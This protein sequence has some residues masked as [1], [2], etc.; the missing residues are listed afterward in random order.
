[1]VHWQAAD[2]DVGARGSVVL[3]KLHV[4]HAVTAQ[5][6]WWG[7]SLKQDQVPALLYNPPDEGASPA[8]LVGCAAGARTELEC[9][10]RRLTACMRKWTEQHCEEAG[11]LQSLG[12]CPR[13][14][15]C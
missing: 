8:L 15:T 2:G 12:A 10:G 1:M 11:V 7:S 4:V 5:Q 9:M 13:G 6:G 3:H 14:A